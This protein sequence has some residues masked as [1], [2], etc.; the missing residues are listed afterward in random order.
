MSEHP[1]KRQAGYARWQAAMARQKREEVDPVV[2]VPFTLTRDD[3][4]MTAGSCFAQHVA[5]HLRNSGFN[6]M[7]TEAAHPILAGD[8]AAEQNYGIFT[9]RYGNI[10]T[11]RQ[12]LQLFKRAYGMFKPCEDIW[13]QDHVFVDPFRPQISPDGFATEEEYW[14]DRQQHL[15]CVRRA[16]EEASVF[17]FTLGL[18]ECWTS[19]IDGAAYPLCPGVAGGTFDEASH[20]FNNLS[21]SDVVSDM[22][23][24]IDLLRSVNQAV[25][26]VLTVSPVPL[27][28]TAVDRHVLVSTTYSKSALRVACEEITSLRQGVAY[29]PS[30]EIIT[31]NHARG[32][33]FGPDLRS[34][35]EDGVAHVMRLFL[36]YFGNTELGYD[37]GRVADGGDDHQRQVEEI[38]RVICDE[39]AID[40]LEQTEGTA[41]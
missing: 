18:T 27:I 13:T 28:A 26:L 22:T 40:R 21:V 4:V 31:G 12:L 7:V 11:S 9:A 29:F 39:E 10:Y 38:V 14:A 1:Y 20:R 35:T 15:A 36:R 23:E 6:F 8:I 5:R 32:A 24:F 25:R 2:A 37:G 16:F 19:T 3:P 17:V 41:S 34:V 30:F 33:Y